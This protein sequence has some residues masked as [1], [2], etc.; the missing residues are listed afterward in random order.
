MKLSPLI[1]TNLL[2]LFVIGSV[3]N[4]SFIGVSNRL[5]KFSYDD[6]QLLIDF[7]DKHKKFATTP[8]ILTEVSNL[9][10]LWDS[11][12][13]EAFKTLKLVSELAEVIDVSPKTDTNH[14][15]F[16]RYGLTDVNILKIALTRPILTNDERLSSFAYSICPIDNIIPWYLIKNV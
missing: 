13:D 1:D 6:Y 10:D 4:G 2:L 3:D 12:A 11:A 7:L 5:K 15:N 16:F 9:I 8:Y 14:E